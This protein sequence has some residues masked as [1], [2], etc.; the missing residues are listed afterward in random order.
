MCLPAAAAIRRPRR[1]SASTSRR[2]GRQ[3]PRRLHD[4]PRASAAPP[5]SPRLTG[6]APQPP[7]SLGRPKSPTAAPPRPLRRP[8]HTKLWVPPWGGHRAGRRSSQTSRTG[9][10]C[11][12]AA[13]AG[14]RGRRCAAAALAA[15]RGLSWSARYNQC[16]RAELGAAPG[17]A[18]VGRLGVVRPS[19]RDVGLRPRGPGG[20]AAGAGGQCH[21]PG[22]PLGPPRGPGPAAST[23]LPRQPPSTPQPAWPL[24]QAAVYTFLIVFVFWAVHYIAVEIEMPFGR[25]PNDLPLGD[26]NRR[27]NRV[28]ERLLETTAQQTLNLERRPAYSVRYNKQPST[29]DNLNVVYIS[30]PVTS[31]CGQDACGLSVASPEPGSHPAGVE[32]PM[33]LRRSSKNSTRSHPCV[34]ARMRP[35]ASE[36]NTEFL[37]EAAMGTCL[38]VCFQLQNPESAEYQLHIS[39]TWCP[40]EV[41]TCRSRSVGNGQGG[42]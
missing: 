40:P 21:R 34:F 41:L 3:P 8:G 12:R 17:G 31:E 25:R 5:G 10:A 30:E 36:A 14:G 1:L 18:G 6:R 29:C 15:G 42:C 19:R 28:L 2:P 26:V 20:H 4:C 23:A 35:I 11:G 24:R 7:D 13:G 39:T 16:L 37:S 32:V 33:R 38:C 22:A 27:F 9:E